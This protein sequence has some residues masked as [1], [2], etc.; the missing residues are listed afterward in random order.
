MKYFWLC[1]KC[2]QK[3]F[4]FI[5]KK[6]QFNIADYHTKHFPAVYHGQICKKYVLDFPQ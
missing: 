5:W 6:S 2:I 3:K 1:D 4:D